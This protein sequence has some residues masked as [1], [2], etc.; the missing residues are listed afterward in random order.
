MSACLRSVFLCGA[1][2]SGSFPYAAEH[3]FSAPKAAWESIRAAMDE[4]DYKALFD[5][6][7]PAKQ[8]EVLSRTL[9]ETIFWTAR[10]M[11][12]E[13][14]PRSESLLP[15]I[16]LLKSH[17]IEPL[18]LVEKI[19][20]ADRETRRSKAM[21]EKD[22]EQMILEHFTG[23]PAEFFVA[24]R[25]QMVLVAEEF[26][27]AHE[28]EHRQ[29]GNPVGQRE[30]PKPDRF[31][32]VEEHGDRAVVIFKRE[33]PG[34]YEVG[35]QRIRWMDEA[36]IYQKTGD[37]WL[38]DTMKR[39]PKE[40]ALTVIKKSQIPY[41]AEIELGPGNAVYYELEGAE[42]RQNRIAFWDG[43][44]GEKPFVDIP[45]KDIDLPDGSQTM[46]DASYIHRGG[47]T[48]FSSSKKSIYEYFVDPYKITLTHEPGQKTVLEIS[49]A[50]A[51]ELLF[52]EKR[53]A[54]FLK[55]L[56]SPKKQDRFDAFIGILDLLNS[57]Y[58]GDLKEIA[59]EIRPL[60]IDNDSSVAYEAENILCQL[61]DEQTLLLLMD[62]WKKLVNAGQSYEGGRY[63]PGMKR[64]EETEID[65]VRLGERVAN[66]NLKQRNE[67]V[68][69]KAISFL[70]SEDESKNKF[71]IGYFVRVSEPEDESVK[72]AILAA[73]KNPSAEIRAAVL[74]ELRF[75]VAYEEAA[76]MLMEALQD[77]DEKV[78][79][80][81]LRVLNWVNQ[82]ADA[83]V[84]VP[85]LKHHNHNI[86]EMACYALRNM[87]D[88]I[89]V[90]ALLEATR[91]EN[92]Y[93]RRDA[94]ETLGIND[95]KEGIDRIAEMLRTDPDAEVR[96]YAV[97]SLRRYDDEKI[98][99][100]LKDALTKEKNRKV[101]EVLEETIRRGE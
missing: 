78:I 30:A 21:S 79:L 9:L 38:W 54:H 32:S 87:Y 56:E 70:Q 61:G 77:K 51:D 88:E 53:R 86:R 89:V 46:E 99:P 73:R 45:Y 33:I 40:I 58:I 47:V 4:G 63:K 83:T 25:K 52:G 65:P 19:Y 15:F 95:A 60:A 12:E 82:N 49:P 26:N 92:P 34:V 31:V 85:L 28:E 91:D 37:R 101:R 8:R 2:L 36:E 10:S 94:T 43:S 48:T 80:E 14:Q 27:K 35:G 20:N 69:K 42:T 50:T 6:M 17:G 81:S 22:V 72:Q 3:D 100:I 68:K 75:Y 44:A 1:L 11:D 98:L 74:G 29:Q 16:E 76:K 90:K 67:S 93:V 97:R 23:D 55:L 71:A 59:D 39:E 7:T 84:I 57:I 41:R 64:S 18:K 24:A 66:W 96:E 5:S 62:D 13:G